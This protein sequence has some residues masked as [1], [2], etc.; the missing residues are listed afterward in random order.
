MSLIDNLHVDHLI[1]AQVGTSTIVKE[2]ARGGMAIVFIAF[3]RTL[4]RHIA[5]K[6]LPKSILTPST[7]SL[8]QQEAESAAILSHPNIIPIYEIGE[9]DEFLFFS[10]QL[11]RGRSLAG[12]RAM[13]KKHILPSRRLPPVGESIRIIL[14]VLDG[15]DYAHDQGIVHQDMKPGNIL[16]EGHTQRAIITD[17]GIAKVLRGENLQGNKILGTYIYVPPEQIVGGEVDGRSDIYAVGTMLFE[18][19][20]SKL[21]FPEYDSPTTLVNQKVE[22]KKGIFMKKPSELNPNVG[23]EMDRIILKATAYEP[24]NRYET[25]RAFFQDLEAYRDRRLKGNHAEKAGNR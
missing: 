1:G 9:T 12:Y 4:K 25:C 3:Q 13:L 19:L 8:F 5:L 6:V 24:E 7:A 23:E 17:F 21:P 16:I 20:C 14:Q 18:L 11:V 10:M 2:M 22:R 15:L